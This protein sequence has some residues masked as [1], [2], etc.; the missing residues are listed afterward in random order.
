MQSQWLMKSQQSKAQSTTE[1]MLK[2]NG[3]KP[4]RDLQQKFQFWTRKLGPITNAK[5]LAQIP[6]Y[7]TG[8]Q[9]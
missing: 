9:M 2:C 5:W 8:A 7:D 4:K 3:F 6:T 1:A